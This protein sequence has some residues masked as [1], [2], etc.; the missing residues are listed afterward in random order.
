MLHGLAHAAKAIGT[1]FQRGRTFQV[2]AHPIRE[3]GAVVQLQAVIL[4]KVPFDKPL[5]MEFVTEQRRDRASVQIAILNRVTVPCPGVAAGLEDAIDLA[6]IAVSFCYDGLS[7]VR[8]PIKSQFHARRFTALSDSA[9]RLF[10]TVNGRVAADHDLVDRLE[11][12]IGLIRKQQPI[13]DQYDLAGDSAF[14]QAGEEV[15]NPLL[16]QR[17]ASHDRKA[18]SVN[19]RREQG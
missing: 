7:E 14:P 2:G 3:P 19:M 12:C 6:G 8:F 1:R 10:G 11:E 17:F 13:G 9:N 15:E 4:V 18:V 16:Q 5:L